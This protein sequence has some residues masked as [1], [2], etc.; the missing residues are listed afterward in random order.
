MALSTAT[1]GRP[2]ASAVQPAR[3]IGCPVASQAGGAIQMC[4]RSR[5]AP[6]CSNRTADDRTEQG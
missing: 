4:G 3:M 6:N 2:V 1:I 5:A